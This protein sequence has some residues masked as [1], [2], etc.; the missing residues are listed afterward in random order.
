MF[1][2]SYEGML[3]TPKKDISKCVDMKVVGYSTTVEFA[4]KKGW[5]GSRMTE[6]EAARIARAKIKEN[7]FRL[8]SI[9]P[10]I[11]NFPKGIAVAIHS[12]YYNSPSLLGPKFTKFINR[13]DI[14]KAS[15]ELAWGH[16]PREFDGLVKRRFAEANLMRTAAKLPPLYTPSSVNEFAKLKKENYPIL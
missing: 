10:R 3:S 2:K 4:R 11:A 13:G 5:R 7:E 16:N 12:A 9:I 6:E 15:R 1:I 14:D 8:F